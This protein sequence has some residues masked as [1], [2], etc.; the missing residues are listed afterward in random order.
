MSEELDVRKET[1]EFLE[2]LR[3]DEV[4]ALKELLKIVSET[5][6]IERIRRGLQLSVQAETVGR[7]A[8]WAFFGLLG[9][10]TFFVSFAEQISKVMAMFRGP[11]R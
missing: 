6:G 5:G 4:L 3:P 11:V 2:D 8:K 7:F 1:R 10:F 9:I